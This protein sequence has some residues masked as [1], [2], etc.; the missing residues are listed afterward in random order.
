PQAAGDTTVWL[1][2]ADAPIA[3]FHFRDRLRDE[4]REVCETLAAAGL[5]LHLLSG[6]RGAAVAQVAGALGIEAAQAD[7]SPQL[8]LEYVRSL[9]QRGRRVLMVGDGINDAPVLAAADVSV[10]VGRA[11]SLARTAAGVVLLGQSLLDLPAL[12]V[13]ALRARAIV[14]QNLGWALAYN[15]IAIPA[16]AAGW[17]PPWLAAIGMSTSSLLVVLNAV[18][19]IPPARSAG[20]AGAPPATGSARS[21][22]ADAGEAARESA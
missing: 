22:P 20:A 16:A 21:Q 1:V 10:A 18:R 9:Q 8:K 11:T 15:A 19:L 3:R 7:A 13:L 14:R 4:A 6:D 5:R 2:D 12:R 17:V